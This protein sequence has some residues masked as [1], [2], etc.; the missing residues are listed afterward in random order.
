MVPPSQLCLGHLAMWR[1][2]VKVITNPRETIMEHWKHLAECSMIVS[3]ETARWVLRG[4]AHPSHHRA[5]CWNIH[6][7]FHGILSDAL[8]TFFGWSATSWH[9]RIIFRR[10]RR[11]GGSREKTVERDTEIMSIM[12]D[13]T[14]FFLSF[15]STTFFLLGGVDYQRIKQHIIKPHIIIEQI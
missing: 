6:W 9:G 3:L 12:V 2:R 1:L 13:L 7:Y 4:S 10:G 15:F 14:R 11:F 5:P 8:R